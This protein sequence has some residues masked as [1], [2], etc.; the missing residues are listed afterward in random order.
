M[1]LGSSEHLRET[2]EPKGH[3]YLTVHQSDLDCNCYATCQF[4]T[5][6][7]SLCKSAHECTSRKICSMVLCNLQPTVSKTLLEPQCNGAVCNLACP[8][9]I[10]LFLALAAL[11]DAVVDIRGGLHT[12]AMCTQS[13]HRQ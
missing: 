8:V 12:C 7:T 2:S 4:H 10:D 13:V 3:T 5:L 9:C 6:N 11:G 1:E